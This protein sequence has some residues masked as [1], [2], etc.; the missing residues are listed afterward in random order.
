[1][2]AEYTSMFGNIKIADVRRVDGEGIVERYFIQDGLI[3]N[4]TTLDNQSVSM[5]THVL[6]SLAH[7][8][9]P[10]ARNV[11]VLGLG[12]G[13]M[14][15]H[16]LAD[17]L[18]VTVV[19]KNPKALEAAEEHFDFQTKGINY[20]Q[21]DAR[22]FA[23]NCENSYDVA[24]LDLFQGDSTPDYLLT[25]E[26]FADL[27]RCLNKD[28]VLV[29]NT[30]L[31]A[32]TEEP[33]KRLMATIASAF[34]ELFLSGFQDG[35]IFIVGKSDARNV[36]LIVEDTPIPKQIALVVR[37]AVEDNKHI[38]HQFYEYAEPVSDDQNIFGILFS[39]SRLAER[40]YL[41]GFLPARILVN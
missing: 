7:S 5:Y 22:T 6:Q 3:Q 33:N 29:M 9:A 35:N 16:F 32:Q 28:G 17:G 38:P 41:V 13:M 4:R 14:P 21:H 19:E 24:I 15:R 20:F 23:R 25:K 8:Y 10:T 26:F 34:P 36:S 18:D 31:D 40:S 30:I 37:F 39:N 1:M 11:L 12:A 2:T 27:K